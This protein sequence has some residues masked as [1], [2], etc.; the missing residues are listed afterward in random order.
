MALGRMFKSEGLCMQQLVIYVGKNASSK[1]G[2][3][4]QTIEGIADNGMSS[5]TKVNPNLM[6]SSRLQPASNERYRRVRV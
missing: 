3:R 2:R 5:V 4:T 1:V 6:G